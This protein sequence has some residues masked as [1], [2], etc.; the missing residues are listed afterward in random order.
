MDLDRA[1]NLAVTVGCSQALGS[2]GRTKLLA[3]A[4]WRR[5][6]NCGS[7]EVSCPLPPSCNPGG[8]PARQRLRRPVYLLNKMSDPIEAPVHERNALVV[9][10]I[11]FVHGGTKAFS[12]PIVIDPG[13]N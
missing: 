3:A 2:E 9:M 8:N 11:K 13:I 6:W 7:S 4:C 10:L 5:G 1:R 12:Q